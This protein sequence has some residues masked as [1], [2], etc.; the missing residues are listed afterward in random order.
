MLTNFREFLIVTRDVEGKALKEERYRI[1]GTE[2]DFWANAAHPRRVA[3]AQ[4]ERFVDFLKRVMRRPVPLTEPKDVAW[5]LASYAHE[6]KA[7]I[8]RRNLAALD[9]I[10][11]ALED[12]LGVHFK[13]EK[14]DQFFRSTLV[15]TLFYG[16]FSVGVLWS[17][18]SDPSKPA[19]NWWLADHYLRVPILRKL[20]HEIAEFG[21]LHDLNLVEVLEWAAGVLN[22][23]V[24]SEFF[25]KFE[26][27]EAVQYLYEPFLD[28]YDPA[29]RKSLGVWYTPH[30]I[31]KYMVTRVDRVLKDELEIAD[32]LADEQVYILDLCCGTGAYLVEALNCIAKTLKAKNDDALTAQE[33]KRAALTRLFGFEILPASFV[34]AHLQLGLCLQSYGASLSDTQKERLGIFLTN[35]RTGWDAQDRPPLQWSELEEERKGS[36]SVKQRVPILV[37][38]GNPPYNAFAGTSTEEEGAYLEDYKGVYFVEQQRRRKSTAAELPSKKTKRKYRLNDPIAEGGWG[39]K[40]FNLDEFYVRFFRFAELRIAQRTGRGIICFIS[41]FSYREAP[42]SQLCESDS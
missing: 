21:Q 42:L 4:G 23:V 7:R 24:V 1:A 15:Q 25:A 37:V 5:F 28:A 35:S 8:E 19:F 30:E 18:H 3:Q 12:G 27:E 20:F 38:I 40:K 39:I 34:V 11:E 13:G 17:K 32:G 9:T 22:R 31:V 41:S 36:G 14:G 16:V 26:E 10:R 33:I 29:L 6:A 2:S